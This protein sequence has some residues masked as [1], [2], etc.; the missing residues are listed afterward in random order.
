MNTMEEVN[1]KYREIC[2]ALGD[3]TV[4]QK[5]LENQKAHIFKELEELDKKAAEVMRARG[6]GVGDETKRA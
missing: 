2:T 4:K 3:I 1:A 5:G 6:E